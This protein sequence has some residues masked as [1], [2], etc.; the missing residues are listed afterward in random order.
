MSL[1]AFDIL[2]LQSDSRDLRFVARLYL[3]RMLGLMLGACCVASVLYQLHAT[4]LTW[5]LLAVHSF[6]WPHVA[7]FLARHSA[8][9][10]RAEMRN[11]QVDS[12][13][14]GMWIAL[15]QFNLLP[16]VVLAVMLS[17][18][19]INVGGVRLLARTIAWQIGG[20]VLTV[21]VSGLQ[22]SPQT[23]TLNILATLP[24][25][26]GYPMAIG[27][28]AHTLL[29][30]TQ[31]LNRKL[32]QLNR[33]DAMTGL[34]N[35]MHWQES[36]THELHR[37]ERTRQPASLLMI[38]ID[39]FKGIND[40]CGHA[41]GD[42]VIRAIAATIH[43]NTRDIDI[44][45]RYGGDEFGVVLVN[46]TS[47]SARVVAERIRARIASLWLDDAPTLR[48]SVSIGIA[49]A[50]HAVCDVRGWVESADVALYRAKTRGRNR[51]AALS[52]AESV[53][54]TM[55]IARAQCA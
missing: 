33:V 40:D 37:F 8:A 44:A 13:L 27:F 51:V 2:S 28:V 11:L 19:K 39:E 30:R 46:T 9:P 22:F 50:D 20:C 34:L 35:R 12:A 42:E 10:R 45:G 32:E 5:A 38:D 17:F 18:D 6:A 55:S 31:E 47:A 7:A 53:M 43:D 25:L 49:E 1:A 14:G 52:T 29:R 23:G 26:I 21:L 41:V 54:E 16:C 24:L 4:S 3:L 48:F 36:V 15:M